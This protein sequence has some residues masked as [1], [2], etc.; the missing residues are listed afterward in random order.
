MLS[1]STENL[2]VH[3]LKDLRV[4]PGHYGYKSTQFLD[5]RSSSTDPLTTGEA[6]LTVMDNP[7]DS[8]RMTG[9]ID[10][11]VLAA[12]ATCATFPTAPPWYKLQR[13]LIGVTSGQ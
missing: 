2:G 5:F 11:A 10:T 12:A 3:E 7:G 4:T 1:A 13:V 8:T 9:P 6:E